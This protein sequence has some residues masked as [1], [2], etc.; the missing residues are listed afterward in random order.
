VFT[1]D[2]MAKLLVEDRHRDIRAHATSGSR[3]SADRRWG[4]VRRLLG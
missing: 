1:H 4:R 3:P 2:T